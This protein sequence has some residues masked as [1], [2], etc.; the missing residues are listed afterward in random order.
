METIHV[1]CIYMILLHKRSLWHI[2]DNRPAAPMVT[3]LWTGYTHV[4]W[5]SDAPWRWQSGVSKRHLPLVV[6]FN[7]PISGS[8]V[9][10]YHQFVGDRA[11]Q[12][13]QML[14]KYLRYSWFKEKLYANYI[15][16]RLTSLL[17]G[18]TSVWT[19]C[20]FVELSTYPAFY[21]F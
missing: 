10:N 9:A 5:T 15:K 7:T 18:V 3:C 8:A 21:N 1:S 17:C 16:E 14:W 12:C 6:S 19:A 20:Y 4:V 2:I 11:T 13:W